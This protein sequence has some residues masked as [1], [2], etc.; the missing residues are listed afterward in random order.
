MKMRIAAVGLAIAC[1]PVLAEET[2]PP[3]QPS[4]SAPLL[5]SNIVPGGISVKGATVTVAT[6]ALAAA[7]L[8][9]DGGSGG[10]GGTTGTTGTTGTSK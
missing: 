4:D 5:L 3:Q 9:S 10:N 8:N 1:G 7:M 2:S 6:V